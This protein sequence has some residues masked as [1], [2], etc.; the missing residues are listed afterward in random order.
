MIVGLGI[1]LIE[2]ERI[3]QIHLRHP[4]RFLARICTPA[5]AA[6][7]SMHADPAPR[8]AGRWAA[9]EAALKALGTG[10]DDGIRW[11]DV[12]ILNDARGKPILTFHA[13][14]RQRADALHVSA[15]HISITHSDT[16]A[17]AEVILENRG[18]PAPAPDA[19]A[20]A[21]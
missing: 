14:A 1:D 10:L 18:R 6:Y 4:G 20:H 17:M 12:E 15:I 7:V 13:K 2:I 8:F 16:M 3:R 5:E 11:H 21:N 9:K 19:S